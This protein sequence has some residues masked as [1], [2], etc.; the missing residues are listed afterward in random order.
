MEGVDDAGVY[1]EFIAFWSSSC[2]TV[3]VPKKV[4]TVPSASLCTCFIRYSRSAMMQF[5]DSEMQMGKKESE[6][7][8]DLYIDLQNYL[9]YAYLSCSF[10]CCLFFCLS[11]PSFFSI[12]FVMSI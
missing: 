5:N 4:T 8:K 3:D 11:I 1:W 10:E 12:I 7:E 6:A 9:L 2:T